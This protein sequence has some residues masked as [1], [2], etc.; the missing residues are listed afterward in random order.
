MIKAKYV[1]YCSAI[2]LLLSA[3]LTMAAEYKS[4]KCHLVSAK[5]GG[6][7]KFYRWNVKDFKMKQAQ[8]P[9][10]Q[11]KDD[12][13]KKYFIYEVVE[14]VPLTEDFSAEESRKLDKNTPR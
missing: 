9:G 7:I 12:K 6:E 13:G 1:I 2:A 5:K 3:P 4:Y 8:L 14:C 11:L 10:K